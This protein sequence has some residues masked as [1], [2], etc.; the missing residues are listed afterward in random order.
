MNY[1]PQYGNSQY[2]PNYYQQPQQFQQVATLNGKI[3]EGI[4]MCKVCDIPLGSFGVF[5]K[6]D[7]SEIYLKSWNN[8]GTTSIVTYVPILPEPEIK[9]DEYMDILNN[10][11]SSITELKNSIKSSS[12]VYPISRNKKKEVSEDV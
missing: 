9:Q 10:I 4:E 1:Y 5:P 8:D 11:Q 7:K 6:G 3:V 12:T 2:F